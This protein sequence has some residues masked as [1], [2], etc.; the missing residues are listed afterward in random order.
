MNDLY[1]EIKPVEIKI[2]GRGGQGIVNSAQ[3]LARAA[4]LEGKYAQ[5]FPHFGVERRNSPTMSFVRISNTVIKTRERVYSPD[6]ILLFD[7]SLI[8]VMEESNGGSAKIIIHSASKVKGPNMIN[9]IDKAREIFGEPIIN[10]FILGYFANFS[11]LFSLNS[12]NGAIE[13]QFEGNASLI[14]K[15]KSAIKY[16]YEYF[17][18][19]G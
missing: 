3:I 12:L 1:S 7:G 18:K 17:S 15:N 11:K 16:G 6:Y 13:Q 14:E 19:N 5:A 10:V 9:F 4:F 8:N 2:Y